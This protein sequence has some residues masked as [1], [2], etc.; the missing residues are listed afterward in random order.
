MIQPQTRLRVADNTGAREIMCIRVINQN[1]TIAHIAD[2][3]LDPVG[4]AVVAD[5]GLGARHRGY[6]VRAVHYKVMGEALMASLKRAIGDDWT[7]EVEEG[8]YL[9]HSL[10]ENSDPQDEQVSL[11]TDPNIVVSKDTEIVIDARKAVPIT[12]E[13]P[14]P[15]EQQDR[16]SGAAR[17]NSVNRL[18]TMYRAKIAE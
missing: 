1:A 11:F 15:A 17:K 6:G 14:K 5:V 12:I 8:T 3:G 9:L 4:K 7:A 2:A 16:R 13:T 10:V 18:L